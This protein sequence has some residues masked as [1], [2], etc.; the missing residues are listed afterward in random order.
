MK[1]PLCERFFQIYTVQFI[2]LERK[3]E[4]PLRVCPECFKKVKSELDDK[5]KTFY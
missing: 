4:R 5:Q 1:C 3:G 2:T